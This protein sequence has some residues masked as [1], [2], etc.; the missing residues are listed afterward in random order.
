M[1]NVSLIV[2]LLVLQALLVSVLLAM[3]AFFRARRLS[4]LLEVARHSVAA[5]PVVVQD[6]PAQYL[7][8][9]LQ[10]TRERLGGL[11]SNPEEGVSSG[12]AAGRLALRAELLQIETE[13]AGEKEH[14]DASWERLDTRMQVL[15][16]QFVPAPAPPVAKSEGQEKVDTKQLFDEQHAT[17]EQLKAAV[18]AA[19]SSPDAIESLQVQLDRLGRTARELTFCVAIL[20]DENLFLRDQV[21]ALLKHE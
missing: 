3:Y 12:N 11:D 5:P 18:A 20:E 2:V 8:T 15:L 16:A 9:Q 13:W 10:H 7:A 17:I 14:D 6:G 19:V 4:A 21:A 1:I